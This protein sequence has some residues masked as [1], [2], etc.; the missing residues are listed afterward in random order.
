MSRE[1][2]R[3]LL[4]IVNSFPSSS[5]F[6]NSSRTVLF[7]V[8]IPHPIRSELPNFDKAFSKNTTKIEM[9]LNGGKRICVGQNIHLITLVLHIST[10]VITDYIYYLYTSNKEK[11]INRYFVK[12]H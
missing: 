10:F 3:A 2:F 1:V 6:I 8:L 5:K 12:K 7:P 9:E 4:S 11:T